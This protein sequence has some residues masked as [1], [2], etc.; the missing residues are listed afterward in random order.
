MGQIICCGTAG[1]SEELSRRDFL[2]AVPRLYA[3]SVGLVAAIGQSRSAVRPRWDPLLI[4]SEPRSIDVICKNAWGARRPSGKFRKH[5]IKR[6][7]VH[8]SGIVLTDNRDAPRHFRRYQ[9]DHQAL[10]WPDIAYHLLIDR[11]GN[12]YRGRPWWA[13]GNTR[14][15]YDTT[16]H[17]LVMCDGNFNKQDISRLQL[18][19]LVDVLAAACARFDVS[20]SRIKSH[21]DYAATAC[22]GDLLHRR[23]ESGRVRRR[24]RNRLQE[25]GAEFHRLC[26][27]AGARRVRRIENG[28]D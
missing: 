23:F 19:A 28:T 10:G 12:V 17:L 22:P 11:H 9:A 27:E 18:T 5:T 2:G 3:G 1:P 26:G 15:S 8:H 4:S 25:G 13:K 24:V 21:R 16:G 7:T 14:T 20:R 6:I